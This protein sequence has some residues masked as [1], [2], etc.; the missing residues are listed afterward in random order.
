MLYAI[1]LRV[2]WFCILSFIMSS[3]MSSYFLRTVVSS[4]YFCFPSMIATFCKSSRLLLSVCSFPELSTTNSS[5]ICSFSSTLLIIPVFLTFLHPWISCFGWGK[6]VSELFALWLLEL[7][8][9][10]LSCLCIYTFFEV[11]LYIVLSVWWVTLFFY[12]LSL[13]YFAAFHKLLLVQFY[14]LL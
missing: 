6:W 10:I 14:L 11:S 5:F 12:G 7:F 4:I 8:G 1:L 2:I 3:L 9:F 13:L